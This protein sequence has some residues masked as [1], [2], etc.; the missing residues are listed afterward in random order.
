M[1]RRSLSAGAKAST[2]AM[3]TRGIFAA[4]RPLASAA[5]ARSSFL[6]DACKGR[7][8]AARRPVSH[9]VPAQQRRMAAAAKAKM[10]APKMVFIKGEEMTHYCMELI[11]EK[12]IKPHIDTSAWEFYDLSCKSRDATGDQV[13]KDAVEAGARIGAI[14]K[15]PTITP[16]AEQTKEMGLKKQLPSP[17]GAMRRGWYH[18][19]MYIC[20][21]AYYIAYV[22]C[23]RLLCCACAGTA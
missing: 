16:S 11:M 14:F 9:V 23:A 2:V 3:R 6:Q 21:P 12:W 5:A 8:V 19:T 1:L 7:S 22:C 4:A 18:R 10:V 20:M 13:L 17:N 15:E